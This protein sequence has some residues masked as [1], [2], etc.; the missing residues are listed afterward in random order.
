[1]TPTTTTPSKGL[2]SGAITGIVIVCLLVVLVIIIVVMAI[3][4]FIRER[5]KHKS[6]SIDEVSI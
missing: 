5:M 3:A 6:Y 4:Y 1:M 2:S